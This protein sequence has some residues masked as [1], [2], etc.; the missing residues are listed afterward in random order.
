MAHGCFNAS[1]RLAVRS[2]FLERGTL[3]TRQA[4]GIKRSRNGGLAVEVVIHASGADA[5]A[6]ANLLKPRFSN[7]FTKEN[8]QRGS[9][10]PF[11]SGVS[12]SGSDDHTHNRS[13]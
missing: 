8:G 10:N 4:L 2:Q 3:V 9:Q 6:E 11:A 7:P 13:D 5:S 12:A 1:F